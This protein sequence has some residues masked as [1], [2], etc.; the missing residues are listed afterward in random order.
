[1]RPIDLCTAVLVTT[2]NRALAAP[3]KTR[4]DAV[5]ELMGISLRSKSSFDSRVTIVDAGGE[6]LSFEEWLENH[7]AASARLW[8]SPFPS[9]DVSDPS[10]E[11]LPHEVREA[12]DNGG[13]GFLLFADGERVERF[14]PRE[15]EPE[16]YDI[17]GP[18]LLA[19][20]QGRK[21][22]AALTEVLA[23]E[24]D[25]EVAD[26]EGSL[27]HRSPDEMQDIVSRF[28]S[29]GAEVEYASAGEDGLDSHEAE[30][31]NDFFASASDS[32]G[33]SFEYLYAGPGS[34]D[35]LERDL[36]SARASLA[37]TLE[38]IRDF[39]HAHGLRSWSKLFRRSHLRLSLEPQP[40]EDLVELL[41]LNDL[42]TPAIQL[43]LCAASSDV[44]G[45]MGSWNDMA[46]EGETGERYIQLSDRLLSS[47]KTGLRTSLNRSVR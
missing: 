35:E 36:D 7:P 3:S 29:A 24:L 9:V 34:E 4:W 11:S 40:V 30:Q 47:V 41:Q 32:P 6:R 13:I 17:S 26:L 1:M 37:S 22:A 20:I 44:F 8:V 31:W 5:E 12:I 45:G 19:F 25:T 10:L 14:V 23:R 2:G 21:H 42:P 27:G 38:A 15:V 16:R 39:A 28:M 43:A 33:L 18:Q 46:F